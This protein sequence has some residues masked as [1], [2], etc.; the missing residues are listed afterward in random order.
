MNTLVGVEPT[1]SHIACLVV[2]ASVVA[3]LNLHGNSAKAAPEHADPAIT[4]GHMMLD[5]VTAKCWK[6]RNVYATVR[7][8]RS[9]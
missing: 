6:D 2:D 8:G 1:D 3:S 9:S 5:T 7:H 4:L